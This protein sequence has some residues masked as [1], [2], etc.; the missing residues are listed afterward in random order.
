MTDK[1]EGG[2]I[3]IV[4]GDDKAANDALEL[5]MMRLDLW[6]LALMGPIIEALEGQVGK[7]HESDFGI[8]LVTPD[9]MGYAVK[10]GPNSTSYRARQNVI[11]EAGMLLSSLT[12]DRMA[13]IVKNHV[14]LPS[15]LDGILRLH[16]N[17]GDMRL[18]VPSL[19]AQLAKCGFD[20]SQEAISEAAG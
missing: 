8:V 4:H 12:R 5:A 19:A 11:L 9:D 7:N 13:L 15:N 18:I 17:G 14:E 3:F 1:K 10:D 2:R 16:F 6:P 20:I